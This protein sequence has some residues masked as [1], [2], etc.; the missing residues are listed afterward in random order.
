MI[1]V[2]TYFYIRGHWCLIVADVDVDVI[3]TW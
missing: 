1:V 3:G 2:R